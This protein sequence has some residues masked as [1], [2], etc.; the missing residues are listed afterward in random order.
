MIWLFEKLFGK[1]ECVV[2]HVVP[3][4]QNWIIVCHKHSITGRVK[5]Y[6]DMGRRPFYT[7]KKELVLQH[8]R[9]YGEK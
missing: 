4:G 3:T 9:N 8:I 1:W 7:L 5:G 2:S 6:I